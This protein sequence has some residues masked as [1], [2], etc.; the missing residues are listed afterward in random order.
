VVTGIA[1][2]P[3]GQRF[4]VKH[5]CPDCPTPLAGGIQLLPNVFCPT[6][7]GSGLITTEQLDQWQQRANELL[8]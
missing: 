6:C 1:Q 4:E 3:H 5:A 7:R 8:A 2:H